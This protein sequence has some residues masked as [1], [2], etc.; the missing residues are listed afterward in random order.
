MVTVSKPCSRKR[1]FRNVAIYPACF[2]SQRD[3]L[4]GLRLV[5]AELA[6]TAVLRLDQARMILGHAASLENVSDMK[7]AVAHS[8]E[9]IEQVFD[10]GP[11]YS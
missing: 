3:W 8:L 4:S 5:V 7:K 1:E 2:Q 6:A 10:L 9:A 11:G